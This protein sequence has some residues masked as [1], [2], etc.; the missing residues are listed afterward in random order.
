MAKSS[1]GH[2][3]PSIPQSQRTPVTIDLP[4]ED[5]SAGDVTG[6]LSRAAE[7]QTGTGAGEAEASAPGSSETRSEPEVQAGATAESKAATAGES[8]PS[9][10]TPEGGGRDEPPP[11]PSAFAERTGGRTPPPASP[12]PAGQSFGVLIAAAVAGGVV[13][14][15][16]VVV[17][18]LA[19]FFRPAEEEG[20]D[21]AG[22]I[23]GLQGQ[24]DE[25]RSETAALREVPQDEA[26]APL[27]EQVAAL[28]QSVG[29]LRE[30]SAAPD[31]T[32]LQD[33]QSRL[34]ELEESALAADGAP[35]GEAGDRLAARLGELSGEVESLRNAAPD[36]S[37][38][39]G[40]LQELR[41]E[42][43]A[44]G[45]EV[46]G[47]PD[48][49][50]VAEIETRLQEIGRQMD[51][52]TALAPAVAASSLS[53]ALDAGRPFAGEL[54]ALQALG[55]DDEAVAALRPHA[56][57]GLPTPSELRARFEDEI[58]RVD[59]DP[60]VPENARALD[61]LIG[62]ARGLVEVRPANPTEGDDP[63]AVV[64]RIRGALQ[65]GDLETAL[66]EWETLPEDVKV[67]TGDWAEAAE[68][69]KTAGDLAARLRSDALARLGTEG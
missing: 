57:E 31:D 56:D 46:Q 29:E 68:T 48:E 55:V 53:S 28:E 33:V 6:P 32:A 37:G 15:F 51:M 20:P 67:A 39:D 4:A 3:G 18:A 47:L 27:R 62:S 8:P 1:R 54:A 24:V 30:A 19:G 69:Q 38:L 66:S 45:S 13:V 49:P 26:V 42:V 50:R 61:R 23:E 17:L 12:E 11:T 40:A 52:A 16:V 64:T 43:D 10:K 2:R 41:Q 60:E 25:L 14:A 22:E 9:S 65:S 36:L 58:A 35:A 5:V 63:G 7:E 44:L 59:L 21:L 34:A